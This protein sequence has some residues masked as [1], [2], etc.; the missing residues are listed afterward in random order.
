MTKFVIIKGDYN[1]G[2]YV[3]EITQME[4]S[5][6]RLEVLDK[7]MA[8]LKVFK[9]PSYYNWFGCEHTSENDEV[10][11]EWLEFFS[12]ADLDIIEGLCPSHEN[13]IHSIESVAIITGTLEGSL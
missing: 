12:E 2:D 4:G 8:V 3:T 1:D 7:L 11:A 13:G 5:D 10:R 9:S 6:P